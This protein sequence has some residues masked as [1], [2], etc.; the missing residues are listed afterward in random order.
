MDPIT[1]IT[2]MKVKPNNIEALRKAADPFFQKTRREPG[3]VLYDLY[4]G[5]RDGHFFIFHEVWKDQQAI[6]D[7]IASA[8]FNEF[9]GQ[10]AGLLET[11]EPGSASPFQVTM[12]EAFNPSDPPQTEEVIV[13]TRARA[14]EESAG[15]I[16]GDLIESIITPSNKEPGCLGYDLYLN[17]DDKRL[18]ILFE[19]W[20]GFGAI[21]EHMQTAHFNGFMQ[22]AP[23][24]LVPPSPDKDDLF[25]VMICHPYRPD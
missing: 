10:A 22:S 6:N 11:M 19:Q 1:V 15:R 14:S 21:Q 18:L 5:A 24:K 17:L 3:C 13:A 25:E 12:A 16:T 20:K 4:Q 23:E 2:R 7:H 9:M 8:H